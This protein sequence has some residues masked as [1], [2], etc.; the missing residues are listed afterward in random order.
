MFLIGFKMSQMN[1]TVLN[2]HELH[3]NGLVIPSIEYG[4]P[5]GVP[6]KFVG[7]NNPPID[8]FLVN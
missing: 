4:D 2:K 3:L 7:K 5:K 6:V 1:T 8:V